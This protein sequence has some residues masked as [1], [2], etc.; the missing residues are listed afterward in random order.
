MCNRLAPQSSPASNAGSIRLPNS[1]VGVASPQP[2]R[3]PVV[4]PILH[5]YAVL[6]AALPLDALLFMRIGHYYECFFGDA[7]TASAVLGLHRTSRYGHAMA[8]FAHAALEG[9]AQRLQSAGYTVAVAAPLETV[10]GHYG[11]TSVRRPSVSER[12]AA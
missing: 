3:G 1:Q 5:D 8:G 7:D 10:P 12:T 6:K 4:S 2:F 11:L 9:Y